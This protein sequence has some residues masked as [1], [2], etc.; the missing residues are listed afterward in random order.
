MSATALGLVQGSHIHVAYRI[1]EN[2]HPEDGGI[3]I[4]IAGIEPAVD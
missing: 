3:E 2:T 4:E 1:R